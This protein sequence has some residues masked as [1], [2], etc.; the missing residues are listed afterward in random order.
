MRHQA[1]GDSGTPGDLCKRAAYIAELCQT[2]DGYGN[3]LSASRFLKLIA[4]QSATLEFAA[5][6]FL[7]G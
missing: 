1:W 3:E 6:A 4:L 5:R 7:R 2:V